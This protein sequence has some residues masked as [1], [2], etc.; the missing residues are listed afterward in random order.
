VRDSFLLTSDGTDACYSQTPPQLPQIDTCRPR[1]HDG[2]YLPH[3]LAVSA[4]STRGNQAAKVKADEN[5]TSMGATGAHHSWRTIIAAARR[6]FGVREFRPGQRE[7]I[8]AALQGRN[9][10]GLLPTGAGKSLCFQL[11]ALFLTGTV[12]V[13]SPLIALMQDQLAHLDDANIEAARLDS[14]VPAGQ[15]ALHEEEIRGYLQTSST[16]RRASDC[17]ESWA[18]AIPR[19]AA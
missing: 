6:R 7:L 17:A 14:T 11:P 5:G 13:V 2:G 8:E 1:V 19:P 10:L 4:M 15:Q 16:R 9:A 12:V 3:R 18:T